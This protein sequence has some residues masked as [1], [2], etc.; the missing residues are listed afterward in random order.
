MA[1]MVATTAPPHT[2]VLLDPDGSVGRGLYVIVAAQTGVT[3]ETQCGGTHCLSRHVEGF[4]VPCPSEG[5]EG[6]GDIEERLAA[7]FARHFRGEAVPASAWP[8]YLVDEL[9]IIVRDVVFWRTPLEGSSER[10]HLSLDRQRLADCI[11]AWVPV[12][13]PDGRGV[14]TFTN[15]D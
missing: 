10:L 5:F 4:L 6:G 14:L 15:S 2:N 12:M 11:E 8:A 1:T 3:Y 13:T 9:S 7:F